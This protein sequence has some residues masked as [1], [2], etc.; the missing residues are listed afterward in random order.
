[1]LLLLL[2]I[3]ATYI[4]EGTSFTHIFCLKHICVCYWF[5]TLIS[6]HL[7]NLHLLIQKHILSLTL[8]MIILKYKNRY[9][10]K[11]FFSKKYIMF[12]LA[13]SSLLF[14]LFRDIFIRM[15]F[16]SIFF[17]LTQSLFYLKTRTRI[18]D[19]VTVSFPQQERILKK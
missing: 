14:Y 13:M 8:W 4:F 11:Y 6:Y 19:W 1:M 16:C 17:F 2:K 9:K 10:T 18:A 3:T 15:Y 7:N 5:C 12:A